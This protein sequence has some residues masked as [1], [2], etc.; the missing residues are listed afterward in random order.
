MRRHGWAFGLGLVLSGMA[1][2][3]PPADEDRF[4]PAP[5]LPGQVVAQLPGPKSPEADTPK[6]AKPAPMP[7]LQLAPDG[8]K[9]PAA[10]L[11][12]PNGAPPAAPCPPAGPVARRGCQIGFGDI[13]EWLLFRSKSRQS[14]CYPPPYYPP[15]Y[16][17]FLCE[18][19]NGHS[20]V[21]GLPTKPGCANGGP[22]LGV[23]T[24]V[25]PAVPPGRLPIPEV[26]AA[27]ES[28]LGGGV[29]VGKCADVLTNFE[30]VGPGLGFTPG[31]APTANP[32]T[33]VKPSSWRPR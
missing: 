14:G 21:V 18:P 2:A 22:V 8:G 23:A 19:G 6:D 20:G 11:P 3:Q 27:P 5:D 26:P 30:P 28:A 24:A 33:Q 12:A 15:L 25:P 1:A 17:W 9:R 29:T 31:A 7:D 16:T 32:T 10:I 4:P 13:Q